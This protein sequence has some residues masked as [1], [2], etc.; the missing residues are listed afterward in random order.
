MSSWWM[1]TLYCPR[2]GH[3]CPH[4]VTWS[5]YRPG[6]SMGW[7]RPPKP[8]IIAV[9]TQSGHCCGPRLL[10]KHGDVSLHTASS[11]YV[12][13]WYLIFGDRKRI[14]TLCDSLMQSRHLTSNTN[15]TSDLYSWIPH[16]RL[17]NLTKLVVLCLRPVMKRQGGD[18]IHTSVE[19]PT[20]RFLRDDRD[21]RV[22][23][24][25]WCFV[26]FI[27]SKYAVTQGTTEI[28]IV[29]ALAI[30][31]LFSGQLNTRHQ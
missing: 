20:N 1:I 29:L 8:D 19:D 7:R 16:R 9:I 14:L 10:Y 30:T 18:W 2:P 24:A 15:H 17:H 6:G 21:G 4:Q 22:N 5:H 13:S 11:P 25:V 26:L 12:I 31:W 3:Y 27:F 23:D 28:M